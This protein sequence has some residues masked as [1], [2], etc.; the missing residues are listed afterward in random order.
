[1]LHAAAGKKSKAEL[2]FL[3]HDDEAEHIQERK[4]IEKKRRE[5]E[6]QDN[7]IR[8]PCPRPAGTYQGIVSPAATLI[9]HIQSRR[10]SGPPERSRCSIRTDMAG[11]PPVPKMCLPK[12]FR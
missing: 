6:Q 8:P 1:M 3:I 7:P 2:E 4:K 11:I 12:K 10:V 5:A 9:P